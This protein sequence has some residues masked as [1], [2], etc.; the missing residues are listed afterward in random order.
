MSAKN[1]SFQSVGDGAIASVKATD[2][3]LDVKLDYFK[4]DKFRLKNVNVGSVNAVLDLREDFLKFDKVE[5]EKGFIESLLPDEVELLNA[6]IGDINATVHTDSGDYT[7]SGV[8]LKTIKDNDAY[9]AHVEG[10][11]VNL[12]FSFLRSARLEQGEV[13]QL[14][15]EIYVKNTKFKIFKSGT[16]TLNGDLDLSPRAR[17]LYD[18]K[19]ELSGLKCTDVFPDAWHRHLTGEVR[20]KFKIKP[21]EGTEPKIVGWLEIRDG[22]LQALPILNKV[23]YY[24]AEPKYRTLKFQKFE[25]DFEKFREQTHLRNIILTSRE[26]V[27]I[28]GD[29]KINGNNIDGLFDVGVPA[30]Y[31]DKIP[32]AKDGVFKPG[33]DQLL[34]TKVRIGG[35]FDDITEDLSDRLLMAATEEMI[36]RA[37]SM[38]GE[39]ISPETIRILMEGGKGALEGLDDVL[40]GDKGVLEGGVDTAKGLLEGIT[41]SNK[42]KKGEGG[43]IPKIP[44][45]PS[46]PSIPKIPGIPDILPFL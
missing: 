22:T 30:A 29:I 3:A 36:R 39:A 11:I 45:I 31:L 9:N 18:M 23:S 41:G 24:L 4:R 6:E 12:P 20:G 10:G 5:K 43:L 28:E 14:D 33:K 44:K 25:C 8:K 37:L 27:Q 15:E 38:G 46:I 7:I 16:I 34:W 21:H 2:I 35:D 19:G 17:H 1:D 26:L 40:K 32:G 42:E 13:I